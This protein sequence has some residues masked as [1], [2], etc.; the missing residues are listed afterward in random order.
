MV[1]IYL[2]FFPHGGWKGTVKRGSVA[3][4][5]EHEEAPV[6]EAVVPVQLR[7]TGMVIISEDRYRRHVE[8]I[9]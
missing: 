8:R 6:E 1:E 3:P 5:S 4:P 9:Q 2:Q 7:S